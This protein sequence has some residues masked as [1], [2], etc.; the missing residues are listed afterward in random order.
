MTKADHG[1]KIDI[2]VMYPFGS[3]DDVPSADNGEANIAQKAEYQYDSLGLISAI[4]SGET[5][6]T[7]VVT[8]TR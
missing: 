1:P 3:M 2:V 4:K 7:K 5:A 8:D 6:L